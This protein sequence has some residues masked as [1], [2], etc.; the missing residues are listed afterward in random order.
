MTG[1]HEQSGARQ[2][3]QLP[4]EPSDVSELATAEV[5]VGVYDEIVAFL[6][7]LAERLAGLP[8]PG[9][10]EADVE[11]IR[12][13]FRSMSARRTYWHRRRAEL[14]AGQK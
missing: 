10:P 13:H 3:S 14:A 5:W 12:A 1:V 6:A 9:A 4:G 11:T 7:P 8:A 2:S